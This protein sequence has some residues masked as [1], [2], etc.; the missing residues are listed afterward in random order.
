MK[1]LFI[2]R[3]EMECTAILVSI[4]STSYARKIRTKVLFGSFFQL[5]FGFGAKIRTKNARVNVD[6]IDTWRQ[7]KFI[8]NTM[9]IQK[10]ICN[11]KNRIFFSALQIFCFILVNIL[12]IYLI[13]DL[14][15]KSMSNKLFFIQQK[16]DLLFLK[17][18]T[19]KCSK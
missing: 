11:V 12:K 18:K 3:V 13:I 4:S 6:E 1:D 10:S 9:E 14:M 17:I 2:R 7:K 5:R 16:I 15:H 19:E 8:C